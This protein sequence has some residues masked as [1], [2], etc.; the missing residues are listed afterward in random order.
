MKQ[1]SDEIDESLY[2]R[3]LYVMGHEAQRKMAASSVLIVGLNGLGVEVAKNVILAGVKSVALHD[4]KNVTY[5]DLSAQFYLSEADIGSNRAKVSGPKLAELNPHVAVSV[6]DELNLS[7]LK[8]NYKVVV[9]IDVLAEQRAKIA[10]HCHA[11]GVYVVTGDTFGVFGTIFCDFGPN[12]VVH[13]IDGEAAFSSMIASITCDSK[14]LVTVL[15][16]TRHNLVTGDVVKLSE[17]SGM[18]ELNDK[19]FTVEVKDPFSFLIDVDTTHFAPYQRGGYV[20]QVKMPSTVAFKSYS[21]ALHSPGEFVCDFSKI[22]RAGQMHLAFRALETF[23]QQHNGQLPQPGSVEDA[24]AV[25]QIAVALNA[26][27]PD[28]GA[29]FKLSAKEVEDEE[30]LIKRFAMCSRG[31]VSPICALLGGIMGQEVLKACSGKFMPIKQWFY[32]DAIEAMHDE[33][34]PAE[35]V[36]PLGCRYDGQIMVFGRTMQDRLAKLNMFLVGAGAI[37]CEMIKNWAM[38]GISCEASSST[39]AAA[40]VRAHG[41]VYVTDMD[42]I[43]KSNLSRQF[44]FRNTDINT[45]KSTTAVRAVTHMNPAFRAV[46][47][48]SKV[49]PDT[50]TLFNDDFFENLDMVCTALD[51]VEARL[52]I[53]QKC[54]FYHKPMLESGTLGA[55][56]HT[57]IIAPFKTENYGATRDPPEKSIPVCT[58]KHFPN[59][60][61]HTLQWARDWFEEVLVAHLS[62]FILLLLM[63]TI[64]IIAFNTVRL[65]SDIFVG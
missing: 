24:N 2:S 8:D 34:L 54:L 31:Q 51:N 10:D 4:S 48:E 39:S 40:G 35:E 21:E 65:D 7:A 36:V 23:Q 14:A 18:E 37:G 43:E 33:P 3:Q 58:L 11:N 20:N 64:W 5:T 29:H 55:K 57:Q 30:K 28:D 26:G 6:L 1:E 38:M 13:D 12:F 52:Y 41:T 44:L 62:Y 9:L 63:L 16:E 25:F 60:I 15:E 42:Q 22:H 61:D 19:Q 17:V 45:P 56:G 59:Q 53:D 27:L 49:A 47:Y 50:E 32:Y 46:A